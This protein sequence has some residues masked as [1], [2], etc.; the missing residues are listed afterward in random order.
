M[1]AAQPRQHRPALRRGSAVDLRPREGAARAGRPPGGVL[2]AEL[3]PVGGGRA[4]ADP[5]GSR[6]LSRAVVLDPTA[7]VFGVRARQPGRFLSAPPSPPRGNPPAPSGPL[8]L[9][10]YDS[11]RWMILH[12]RRGGGRRGGGA[13]GGRGG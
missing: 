12:G 9:L 1:A 7:V 10:V 5:P 6:P 8:S 4:D 11:T 3:S 2:T 13:G